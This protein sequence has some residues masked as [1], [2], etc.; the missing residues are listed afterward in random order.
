[1]AF[2]SLIPLSP[3]SIITEHNPLLQGFLLEL[4]FS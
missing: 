3:M 2:C 4:I 1:M